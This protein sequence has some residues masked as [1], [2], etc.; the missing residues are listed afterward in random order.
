MWFTDSYNSWQ[1][2][3]KDPKMRTINGYEPKPTASQRGSDLYFWPDSSCLCR[4][5]Q[6]VA[7]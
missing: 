3:D 6:D 7:E 2:L 1:L 4:T 5:V